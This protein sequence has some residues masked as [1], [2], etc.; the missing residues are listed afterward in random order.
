MSQVV[1]AINF[2]MEQ[3][4]SVDQP[5]ALT[6]LDTHAQVVIRYCSRWRFE[7]AKTLFIADSDII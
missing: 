4:S 3:S 1:R 6:M 5:E 2:V 7:D